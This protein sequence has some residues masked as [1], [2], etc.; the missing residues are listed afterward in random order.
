MDYKEIINKEP[1]GS[2]GRL[3]LIASYGKK[4]QAAAAKRCIIKRIKKMNY[5]YK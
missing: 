5:G 2:I 3:D 1:L 4:E